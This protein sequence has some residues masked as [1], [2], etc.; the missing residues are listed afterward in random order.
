MALPLST[1]ETMA[2]RNCTKRSLTWTANS[3]CSSSTSMARFTKKQPPSKV[4]STA[5]RRYPSRRARS[6][7][8]GPLA[9]IAWSITRVTN[10]S[11]ACSMTACPRASLDAKWA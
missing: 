1:M 4:F 7:A 10:S 3:S 5:Y 6:W 8:T 2:W 11:V 9:F